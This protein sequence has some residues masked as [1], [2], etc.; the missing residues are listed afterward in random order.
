[1]Q[2]E[3]RLKVTC[4]DRRGQ[5]ENTTFLSHT[6]DVPFDP[7]LPEVAFSIP[8]PAF[9]GK[10]GKN[11]LYPPSFYFSETNYMVEVSYFCRF[12]LTWKNKSR[13]KSDSRLIGFYYLPK[14][15]PI[16]PPICVLPPASRHC[17]NPPLFLQSPDRL[18]SF[19]RHK[20]LT[21]K[22]W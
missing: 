6:V 18:T 5:P 21:T 4:P 2:L 22:A 13:K 12:S 17:E 20:H 16:S 7:A 9:T 11:T 14:T 1:M 3:G 10:E 8:I 15:N 19:P